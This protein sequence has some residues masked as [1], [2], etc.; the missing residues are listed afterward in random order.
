MSRRQ[1]A[2]SYLLLPFALITLSYAF[3]RVA[4]RGRFATP[5]STYGAGPEGAHALLLLARGLG[6]S[7]EP[8]TRELGN[9]PLG[10]LVTFGGCRAEGVRK[11]SR[12]E[13]EALAHWVEAGGLLISIGVADVLPQ[14]AGVLFDGEPRCDE[15]APETAFEA[16]LGGAGEPPHP[17]KPELVA[18]AAGPPLSYLLPFNVREARP[19]RLGHDAEGTEI[20]TSEQG[21]L[22]L[23]APYGRGRVVLLGIPEALTNAAVSDGGG[24]VFAR[25]LRAF[26][27]KGP[28]MFDEYHLGMGERR[29]LIGYVRDLGYAPLLMQ[30]LLAVLATLLSLS[31]RISPVPAPASASKPLRVERSFFEALSA[32][33][34]QSHD[35]RAALAA[36]ANAA[37]KRI[38][39]SYH[40][41]SVPQHKLEHWLKTR[42][43]FAVA[44]Y[45]RAI[46]RHAREP[47][48]SGETLESRAQAIDQDTSAAIAIAT[49]SPGSPR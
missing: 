31:A 10:T 24:L 4:E 45:T 20:L 11:V 30:G 6:Y 19:L 8:F 33:L 14:G 1:R 2:L 5:Y 43:L 39:H 23:T 47:L 27:P 36:L 13:R 26:A 37:H 7:A 9:L 25:L 17:P 32:L 49:L 44:H 21:T 29:S 28:V 15:P 38:A 12:P 42:G 22:G 48:A 16:W 46:E 41:R 40:A 34:M 35:T 18:E 3:V